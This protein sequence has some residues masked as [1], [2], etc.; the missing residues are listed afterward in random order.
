MQHNLTMVPGSVKPRLPKY[1]NDPQSKS[2]NGAQ[3][4]PVSFSMKDINL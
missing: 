1:E 2:V 3:I 4:A